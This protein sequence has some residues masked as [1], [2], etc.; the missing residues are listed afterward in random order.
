VNKNHYS[1]IY[2]GL[3]EWAAE[4]ENEEHE[5]V[6][7]VPATEAGG[8]E[9]SNERVSADSDESFLSYW[10]QTGRRTTKGA[11]GASDAHTHTHTH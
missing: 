4:E 8:P 2:Q 3:G 9:G 11:S 1:T 6:E 5:E 10:P 7:Q